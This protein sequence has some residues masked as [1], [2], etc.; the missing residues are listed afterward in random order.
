L[1]NLYNVLGVSPTASG[2]E[3][4]K[5]YRSLAMR[6][7]PDRN[8]HPGAASRFN[9][10]KMAY[11]LLSDPKKRAEYNQGLNNRIIIDPDD[12]ALSLWDSL[13]NRCE[14]IHQHGSSR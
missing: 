8:T 11:E 13:F 12:E 7:H 4:R 5:A 10:I 6:H 14:I 1:E 2:D 3:I 9:A